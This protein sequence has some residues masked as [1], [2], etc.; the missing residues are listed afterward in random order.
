MK[1]EDGPI[2]LVVHCVDT[3]GPIGGDVRRN[4]DGTKEFMDNWE[5][6]KSSLSDITSSEYRNRNSDSFGGDL[7]F[8]WFIMD[9][10]GFLTNPKNRISKYHDTY[11]NIKSLN[12]A[13]DSFHW[14]Y[15]QPSRSGAGDQWS[16]DWDASNEHYN[17]LGRRI[18]ERNDFP[19]AFRAGGTIED[20]KC[21]Q[22]LED[23][24]MIDFSNRVSYRSE[25]TNNIFDFNWYGAPLNWVPYNPKKGELTSRGKMRRLI[26]RSV[27]LRSRL[28]ELQYNEVLDTFNQ[29]KKNNRPIIFSYFS[30]DHRDMRDET[31]YAIELLNKASNE[32]SIPFKWACAKGAVKECFGLPTR[33]NKIGISVVD[34]TAL[35]TFRHKIFQKYPFVYTLDIDGNVTYHKLDIKIHPACP[36]YY[37]SCNFKVPSGTL[38]I[39]VACTDMSG[40][41]CVKVVEL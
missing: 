5:D 4:P 35:I 19:E 6:I 41:K 37:Q 31:S 40:D 28:H 2:V 22:W 16:D 20:E 11:D 27:D 1:Y 9:F 33:E 3:E 23:H 18:I 36:D 10:M 15:H 14:H 39:G 7:T 13:V 17:I 38:K 25:P 26:A 32:T 34:K 12:T 24:M 21:S 29:A 8:N 30:H